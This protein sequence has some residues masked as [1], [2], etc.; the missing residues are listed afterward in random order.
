MDIFAK[1]IARKIEYS[2]HES[3]LYIPVTPETTDL[4][5]SYPYMTNVTTFVSQIERKLYY[6]IPFAYKP[7]WDV[8]MAKGVK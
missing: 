8:R 1:V 2:N 3:D 7:W 4:V 5:K 6:D